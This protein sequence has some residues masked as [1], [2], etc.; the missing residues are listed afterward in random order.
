LNELPVI[1]P[2][3]PVR[4]RNHHEEPKGEAQEWQHPQIPSARYRKGY[5]WEADK[6]NQAN[7]DD[8]A[9]R[10]RYPKL[11]VE[12]GRSLTDRLKRYS[13]FVAVKVRQ[14]PSHVHNQL[15]PGFAE[16]KCS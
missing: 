12:A 6:K 11:R 14:P 10:Q 16:D 4:K 9:A 3:E 1:S 15:P 5:K 8:H 7:P 2:I 13:R